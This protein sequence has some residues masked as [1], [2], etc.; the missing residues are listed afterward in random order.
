MG[1]QIENSKVQLGGTTM[2]EWIDLKIRSTV[3]LTAPLKK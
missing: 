1:E 3:V 2:T